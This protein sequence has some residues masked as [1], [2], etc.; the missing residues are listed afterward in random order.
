[1]TKSCSSII[2]LRWL[3]LVNFWTSRVKYDNSTHL[4]S[5]QYPS[6]SWSTIGQKNLGLLQ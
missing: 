2:R 4:A 5:P 6:E 1:M 3:M